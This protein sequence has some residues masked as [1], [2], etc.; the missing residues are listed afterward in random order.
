[1]D[2]SKEDFERACEIQTPANSIPSLFGKSKT[3][4]WKMVWKNILKKFCW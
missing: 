2:L 3:G 4:T 1:M